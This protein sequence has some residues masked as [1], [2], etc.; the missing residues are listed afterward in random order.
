[1]LISRWRHSIVLELYV[2]TLQEI[3]CW[4]W[5]KNCEMGKTE[6]HKILTQ[7]CWLSNLT[8]HVF[9]IM[10]TKVGNL[11]VKFYF[12]LLKCGKIVFYFENKTRYQ[13]S[14][15][16][17]RSHPLPACLPLL[18]HLPSFHSPHVRTNWNSK[19]KDGKFLMILVLSMRSARQKKTRHVTHDWFTEKSS[20]NDWALAPLHHCN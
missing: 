13:I 7:L 3:I 16:L 12:Q 20:D 11:T 5:K 19:C 8:N 14:L 10:T 15:P 9:S 17:P 4:I 1:M 2:L 18:L 6:S